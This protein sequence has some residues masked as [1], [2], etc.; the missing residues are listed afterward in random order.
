MRPSGSAMPLVWAHAEFVKLATSIRAGR[1][2]DRP[3]AVWLRYAGR[4]PHP[5]HAHWAPWMPVATIR[6]GQSL[7]VL[8]DVPTAVRWRVAGRDDAGPPAASVRRFTVRT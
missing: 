5:A 4:R 2:V 1:P 6:R 8:S 7:R 3:E